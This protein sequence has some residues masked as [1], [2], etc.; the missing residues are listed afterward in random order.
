MGKKLII[1][2][3]LIFY[4]ISLFCQK[5]EI[6]GKVTDKNGEPL[7]FASVA[8]KGSFDGTTTNEKGE[9]SFFTTKKGQ[10]IIAG[11][12][13]G[14]ESCAKE[15]LIEEKNVLV[16]LVLSSAITK[17]QEVTITAGSFEAS[18]VKRVA[19]M[20]SRD[21]GTTAGATGDIT[22]A[23]E[24]LPGVQSVG[25]SNGLFVRGGSG[26]E[27]Q[28]LIDEM[29][30][31][32]P[33]YS[34]VP[35]NKQRGRFDPFMFSG[36]VFST[37]GYSAMYGQALSSI[38]ALKSNGLADS[39]NT[40]G[41][42]HAYG[43]NLFH[44]HRWENTSLYVKGEYNNLAPYNNTFK[45]LTEWV[46]SPE[47]IATTLNFRHKISKNDML[48]FYANYSRTNLSMKYINTDSINYKSLFKLQ[49]DNLY[50]NSTYKKY[51]KDE[52]WSIFIGTAYSKNIDNVYIDRTN[53]SENEELTQGKIIVTNNSLP[54]TTFYVG[55]EIQVKKAVGKEGMSIGEINNFYSAGFLEGNLAITPKLGTRIG[56]RYEYSDFSDNNDLAPRVSLA[57][58][59]GKNSQVSFAY[60][61][62]YQAPENEYLYYS[63]NLAF[64]NASHYIA[65]YQ[66]M[67]DKRTFRIELYDKE[68]RRLIKNISGQ[69]K[70]YNNL[71]SGYARGIDIFWRDEKTISNADYWISYSFLDTKRNYHD[72]PI[73]AV[74]D[75]ASRHNLSLV[76]KHWLKAINSLAGFT[77]SYSS[78]RPYYNPQR[79]DREFNKDLTRDYN[80][81]SVNI[82][83][84][85]KVFGRSSVIYASVDNVLGENH[86]YGYHY[87]PDNSGRIP[88]RP[89]SVRSFF[90][91][92]FVST[93]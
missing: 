56:I 13:I 88:V 3:L 64:E 36:T 68:Y 92:F 52:E 28:V 75:F 63:H 78:G 12:S 59:T 44:V 11:S 80:N 84:M 91:G 21:I 20:S 8:L 74:P 62:F 72:F 35:D 66:F 76:Y 25:E 37:G 15:V 9:F 79:P 23:I 89:S 19:V 1:S 10:Q 2:I 26:T 29:V 53:M 83:K 69:E 47:N 85:T 38:L 86:I 43:T 73:A 81:L 7:P 93:Y 67:K 34:P 58:K 70:S 24:T 31:Q 30:V 71:G 32:D 39:T 46:K 61:T 55:T 33:Y 5:V 16:D 60:G 51:F 14:Y 22:K 57:Y 49:N 6:K 41:G 50:I 65:N 87:L 40:G 4:S 45:Q 77:Y 42:I 18:D 17:L 48:K 54:G 27:S 82:S 90:I